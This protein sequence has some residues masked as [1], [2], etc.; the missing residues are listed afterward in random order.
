[1]TF[2]SESIIS[3]NFIVKTLNYLSIRI[4]Y[5]DYFNINH[6][7]LKKISLMKLALWYAYPLVI[8]LIFLFI[9]DFRDFQDSS[10]GKSTCHRA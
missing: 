2:L 4:F 10:V 5:N 3:S 1:M 7:F 9:N 6:L 8:Q